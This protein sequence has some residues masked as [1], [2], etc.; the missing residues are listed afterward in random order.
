[1]ERILTH[2]ALYEKPPLAHSYSNLT[3]QTENPYNSQFHGAN[4]EEN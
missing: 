4:F 1:L 3:L 2:S